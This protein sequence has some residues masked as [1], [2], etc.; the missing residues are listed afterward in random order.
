[1]LSSSRVKMFTKDFAL[2]LCVSFLAFSCCQ[3]LNNGTPIYIEQLGG[4][5][6]F[7]GFLILEFSIFAAITRMFIGRVIDKGTRKRI[8]VAGSIVLF[9]G[10]SGAL[11]LSG[12]EAQLAFR[13]I[14][15]VGFGCV[16]TASST[17]AA[18]V[19]PEERLGEGIGYFGLGQSVGMSVGPA[20]AVA[21]TALPYREGLFAGVSIVVVA[22]ILLVLCCSYEKHPQ[23][24]PESC[25]FRQRIRE[26]RSP[27]NGDGPDDRNGDVKPGGPKG[28]AVEKS[29]KRTICSEL[30][31]ASA[32]PGVVPMIVSCLGYSIIVSYTSLYGTQL[33][34]E[35]PG[36]FFV[37]AGIAMSIIRVGGGSL[38]DK[39]AP[40]KLFS[41]PVLCGVASFLILATARDGLLFYLAGIFFGCSM[42]LAFPLLNS[43]CVKNTAPSRWG[44]ANGMYGM[45]NDLG[46]G[47]GAL[48]WG[49]VID[50][51][52]FVP[53]M[54]CGA[55]MIIV[56]FVVALALFP[57]GLNAA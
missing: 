14:Q 39:I 54:Y 46:I 22:L 29:D 23:R 10:S 17:A 42:G 37:F 2:L 50:V 47:L 35:N 20:F 55:I 18:D 32:V 44:A 41:I 16:T 6:A 1:M 34:I 49:A 30:F 31:V 24:L 8:M 51:V 40:R 48:L 33:N 43:I 26:G 5:T 7:S 11:V 9:V 3:A 36:L 13:A 25:A 12:A 21:L 4:S 28:R 45:A 27:L 38:F 15:G 57:R 56:A 53:V 19:L 52:G